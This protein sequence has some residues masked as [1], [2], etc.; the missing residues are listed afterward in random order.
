MVKILKLH[1]AT[2]SSL[3]SNDLNGTNLKCSISSFG[4]YQNI[5]GLRKKLFNFKCNIISFNHICIVLTETWVNDSF[6]SNTLGLLDYNIYL[7]DRSSL[8]STLN[9]GNGVFIAIHKDFHSCL[10]PS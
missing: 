10:V 8:N 6:Y 1:S 2:H 9:C 4:F 7:Y 5:R 3:T